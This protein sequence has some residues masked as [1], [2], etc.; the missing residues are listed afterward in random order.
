[1]SF[2]NR[3]NFCSLKDAFPQIMMNEE[4]TINPPPKI[5]YIAPK[6]TI[7]ENFE[8]ENTENIEK[9][10]FCAECEHRKNYGYIGT[11]FNEILNLL[12]LLLLLY[13]VIYKPKI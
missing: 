3:S 11:S 6:A 12:L 5:E 9:N 1:M 7:V 4:K 10:E 2:G 13:I 8:P